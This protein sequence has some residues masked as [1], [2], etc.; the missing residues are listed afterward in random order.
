MPAARNPVFCSRRQI[1]IFCDLLLTGAYR[2][3]PDSA[4]TVTIPERSYRKEI[5]LQ[6]LASRAGLVDVGLELDSK[7]CPNIEII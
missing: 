6:R 3:F 2:P 5:K 1:Q 4:G 7:T